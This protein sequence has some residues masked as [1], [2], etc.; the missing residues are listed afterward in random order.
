VAVLRAPLGWAEGDP[1]PGCPAPLLSAGDLD[2]DLDVDLDVGL[3]PGGDD[4]APPGGVVDF[5]PAPPEP[6]GAR[7]FA[8]WSLPLIGCFSIGCPRN[9]RD[10]VSGP[11]DEQLRPHPVDP[12]GRSVSCRGDGRILPVDDC[13]RKA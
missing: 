6:V 12:V 13:P 4:L 5:F 8:G 3:A 11:S 9:I 7:L 1:L 2:G 10:P